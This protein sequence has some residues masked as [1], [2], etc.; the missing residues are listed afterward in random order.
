MHPVKKYI[1]LYALIYCS[2][3]Y[4]QMLHLRVYD[5]TSSSLIYSKTFPTINDLKKAAQNF[6]KEVQWE[7][8]L[9]ASFDSVVVREN[10]YYYYLN[11]QQAFQWAKLR[12]GNLSSKLYHELSQLKTFE[13]KVIRP[14]ML[15]QLFEKIINYYENNGYPF[16]TVKLD[17][18]QIDSNLVSAALFVNP[19]QVIKIDSILIQGSLKINHRFLYQYIGIKPSSLY[20][21]KKLKQLESKMKKLPFVY[22]RQ[23]PVIRITD[24]YNKV[25]IFADHK[26]VSQFDG[27]IGLQPDASGKSILTGNL[28]INLINRIF[29]NA[30]E[31]NIEWQRVQPLTQ[32]FKLFF[33]VPYL[34]GTSFGTQY[35]LTIFKK[36]TSFIDVQNQISVAY[37]FSGINYWSFFYK[38]RN[39]NL[40]STYGLSGIT[41]LPDYADIDTKHYGTGFYFNNLNNI[42]NPS[43]G[44]QVKFNVSVGNKDIRKNPNINDAAYKNILLHSLQYQSDGAIEYYIPQVLSRYG[45]LKFAAKYGFIKGTA[46]L[47]KNELYR[48]GG[49]KSI[50]GFNEQSIFADTYLIPTIEYRFR[51]S[52]YGYFT[53][54]SD[55][56]YYTS[57]YSHVYQENRVYSVGA[58]LQFDTKAGL[59]NLMYALGAN[60]GQSP[61]FRTGKIHAGL[62]TVF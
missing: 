24:R 28:K 26:N 56:G 46:T 21:E 3:Y 37:Y 27:I 38:Q 6:L 14:S 35:Q 17:S 12:K 29:Q 41:T 25:Y 7:G 20:N 34:A 8:Y 49:L 62:I 13:N 19:N 58:G 16:A 60:F 55:I 52:E 43:F 30:E 48:L 11:K 32:N 1:V 50:R 5:C 59:F 36:D 54:F 23:P 31:L 51:Y 18:I 33:S 47:F 61:D 2:V 44:W 15:I 9:L 40:I 10:T 4:P 57:N 45:T 39:S 53:I 22:M 42:Y